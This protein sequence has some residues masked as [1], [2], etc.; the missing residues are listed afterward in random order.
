M[1][2]TIEASVVCILEAH[3]KGKMMNR[4]TFLVL[5]CCFTSISCC[6]FETLDETRLDRKYVSKKKLKES[7]DKTISED[8]VPKYLDAFLY[9][10]ETKDILDK[11][12]FKNFHKFCFIYGDYCKHD[13]LHRF[14]ITSSQRVRNAIFSNLKYVPNEDSA[15]KIRTLMNNP[16]ILRHPTTSIIDL[17][18]LHLYSYAQDEE[19]EDILCDL[20]NSRFSIEAVCALAFRKSKKG[21]I[22]LEQI[23][24]RDSKNSYWTERWLLLF[25]GNKV[26]L[27]GIYKPL[28]GEKQRIFMGLLK[29]GFWPI[30]AIPTG[31]FEINVGDEKRAY[32]YDSG[33]W[34]EVKLEDLPHLS[35]FMNVEKDGVVSRVKLRDLENGCW[36]SMRVEV[37]KMLFNAD[38][39][40]VLLQGSSIWGPL[41]GCWW[42][43]I[44]EKRS[45]EWHLIQVIET[46]VS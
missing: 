8:E 35:L 28:P 25:S 5:I 42:E 7:I 45:S 19:T 32:F 39:N 43:F 2:F 6:N 30:S 14:L 44:L 1:Y 22:L 31:N 12:F 46:A 13:L 15:L 16:Q 9:Y 3:I 21:K 20:V 41:D 17:T 37:D 23:R 40:R 11:D 27:K 24:D 29:S 34:S 4:W 10:I 18:L 26:N 38:K 33:T 36:S